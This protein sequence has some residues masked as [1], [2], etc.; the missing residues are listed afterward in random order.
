MASNPSLIMDPIV[1]WG[2]SEAEFSPD[3]VFRGLQDY[4]HYSYGENY[5]FES[6]SHYGIH[7]EMLKDDARTGTYKKAILRNRHLFEGKV[8]LDVGCGTGILSFFA[9]Q[10][11]AAHVFGIDCAD[12]I[13][14]AQQIV[15][16]N[17]FSDRITLIK[18]KVEEVQLP[19]LKVDIIVSEW[20]G[21]FLLYESMLDTVLFARDKWLAPSG[22]I[23]PDRARIYVSAIEDSKHKSEK[24][25][26]WRNIYGI[27]MSTMRG[28]SLQEPLVDTV[29]QS[30]LISSMCPVLELDLNTMTLLDLDFISTYRL[31]FHHNSQLDGLV[32]WFE[33]NFSA[34]HKPLILSTSPKYSSTH[35][36]QVIFYMEQGVQVN[37]GDILHGSIAVRKNLKNARELDIKLSYKIEGKFD[38]IQYYKLQ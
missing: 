5:Y 29:E 2:S 20:M 34:C 6:Y 1:E 33:V 37:V 27:N 28:R 18:G 7:E 21:Y 26:F 9:V 36:K 15:D 35:W 30:H 24:L 12:I 19:V 3:E 11:G 8:V 25:D 23:F 13:D 22:L 4:P 17:G 10:A 16:K 14:Q 31:Q 38:Q 32:A